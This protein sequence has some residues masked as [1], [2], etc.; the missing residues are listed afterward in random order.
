MTYFND[1]FELLYV[2]SSFLLPRYRTSWAVEIFTKQVSRLF[3]RS[4][5]KV[6]YVELCHV[7]FASPHQ[8]N[9]ILRHYSPA[10]TDCALSV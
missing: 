7:C 1:D 3:G 5:N 4:G 10:E 9:Q 2:S 6:M 8:F